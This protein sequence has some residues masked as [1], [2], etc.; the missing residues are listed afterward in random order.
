MSGQKN[1]QLQKPVHLMQKNCEFKNYNSWFYWRDRANL[2]KI[3][4]TT[5]LLISVFNILQES[6]GTCR[7]PCIIYINSSRSTC[8]LRTTLSVL[9]NG[10]STG[11]WWAD[12]WHAGDGA[13]ETRAALAGVRGGC[14][15]VT[16]RVH[17]T[18]IQT[19]VADGAAGFWRDRMGALDR[20]RS[21]L[22]GHHLILIRG[23]DEGSKVERDNS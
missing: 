2:H 23:G 7:P 10:S 21:P 5:N 20:T 16:V 17:D 14:E 19:G 18:L 11:C 22:T 15:G 9:S 6:A 12:E 1:Q 8:A 3:P 13:F 4:K